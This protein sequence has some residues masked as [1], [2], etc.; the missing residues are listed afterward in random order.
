MDLAVIVVIQILAF[1]ALVIVL[2]KIM[3]STAA[4]EVERLRKLSEENK[5]KAEQL[6]REI[7]ASEKEHQ[8]KMAQAQAQLRKMRSDAKKEAETLKEDTVKKARDEAEKIVNQALRAKQSIREELEEEMQERSVTLACNLIRDVLTEENMKWFHEGLVAD[9]LVAIENMDSE[10][11]E[12]VDI[13]EGA[14]LHT[15]YPL[16][17]DSVER[18]ASAM[19]LH[20]GKALEFK[21]VKDRDVIA[22]ITVQ[23]G[24]IVI[25]GS[26]AGKLRQAVFAGAK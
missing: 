23:L 6:A 21:E 8:K 13:G 17:G 9:V 22:G 14:E 4:N 1:S 10:S 16:N 5:Q 11:L 20:L 3:Y 7:E 19:K 25:D 26:L 2:R 18:L 24:N 12:G 15:P